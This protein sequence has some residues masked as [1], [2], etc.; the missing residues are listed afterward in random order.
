MGPLINAIGLSTVKV[1]FTY[2]AGGE[3]AGCNPICDLG[4]LMYS[5]DGVNFSTFG[6]VTGQLY[7]RPTDSLFRLSL[8]PA[9][10]NSQFYLAFR[11]INDDNAGTSNSVTIDNLLV[12]AEPRRVEGDLNNNVSE[13]INAE[14]SLPAYFYSTQ[15]GEIMIALNN[16]TQNL[17]CVTT[18]ILQACNNIVL[19]PPGVPVP[20]KSLK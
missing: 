19:Y 16:V 9:F 6:G 1:Q 13:T 10:N 7:T 4:V 18:S 2:S 14:G 8:P 17:G 15:D 11:W 3:S 20:K 12:T 5:F